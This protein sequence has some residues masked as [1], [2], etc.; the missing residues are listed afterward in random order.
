MSIFRAVDSKPLC[1]EAG[2]AFVTPLPVV[3]FRRCFKLLNINEL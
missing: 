3:N 1:L 2:K